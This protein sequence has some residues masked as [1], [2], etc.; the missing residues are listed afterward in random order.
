MFLR[1]QARTFRAKDSKSSP[2][3]AMF[4][5]SR[6]VVYMLLVVIIAFIIS[7]TP[8]QI[9]FLGFNLGLIPNKFVYGDVYRT[10]V[11]L[12]FTNSCYN[13]VIYIITNRNFRKAFYDLFQSQRRSSLSSIQTMST[14]QFNTPLEVDIANTSS[15]SVKTGAIGDGEGA[16]FDIKDA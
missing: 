14:T 12:A 7:W 2:A 5:A 9:A 11:V 10:L 15:S 6:R 13:P 16:V 4:R 1:R 8:D 3:A